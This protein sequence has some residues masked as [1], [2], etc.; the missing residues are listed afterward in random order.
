MKL[1]ELNF[2]PSKSDTSLFIRNCEGHITIILVYVDDL[3]VTGSSSE[4]IASL[5]LQLSNTFALKDLGKLHCFLGAEVH[6]QTTGLTL[7]QSKYI[8]DLLAHANMMAQSQLPLLWSWDFSCLN[9]GIH[10]FLTPSLYHNLAGA[11]QY[12]TIMRPDVSYTV[13]KSCQFMHKPIES[14]FTAMKRLLRYLKATIDLNL[15]LRSASSLHLQAFSNADWAGCPDARRFTNGYCIFRGPNL[16]S[17]SSKKQRVV[18]RS[19]TEAE[20]RVLAVATAEV[21]WLQHLL[22]ELHVSLPQAPTLWC[23]KW[24]ATTANPIFHTRTKHIELDFH[25]VREKVAS[26]DLEVRYINS[27]DQLADIFTKS[28]PS[29]RFHL[30]RS[31][32]AV[33]QP[34]ACGDMLGHHN[35]VVVVVYIRTHTYSLSPREFVFNYTFV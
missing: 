2:I 34:L 9:M 30:L 33:V 35:R 27:L 31:K 29:C 3:I 8:R 26:K 11:L 25:F 22:K 24:S 12:I 28:Q 21:T 4:F 5:I 14:H 13:N 10:H 15:Q 17:W 16:V 20:Y 7:T 6:Y 18:A 23:D 32:L 1:L 19:S